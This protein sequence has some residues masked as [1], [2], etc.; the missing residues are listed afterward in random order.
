VATVV[1]GQPLY[2]KAVEI[3]KEWV[4]GKT[5]TLVEDSEITEEE[6]ILLRFVFVEDRFV[7]RELIG[8]GFAGPA[9]YNACI[10]DFLNVYTGALESDAGYASMDVEMY[11]V[12]YYDTPPAGYFEE[13]AGRSDEIVIS[14]LFYNGEKGA[15]EADE[16]VEI[17]NEGAAAIQ[18]KDWTLSDESG[19]V[20][21]FP[22]FG[23]EAGQSCRIYT[24]EA[25]PE[26]CGFNYESAQAIWGNSGDCAILRDAEGRLVDQECY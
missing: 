4:L 22:N 6:G 25:H 3:N 15:Q 12:P 8:S 21:V 11:G 18:L 7:N 1:E 10:D 24:N 2:G 17:R 14:D 16:Y 9:D 20:F 26:W 19:H 5:V 23:L 13:E